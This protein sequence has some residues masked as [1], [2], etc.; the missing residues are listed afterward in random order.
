MLA[1]QRLVTSSYLMLLP[2]PNGQTA[3]CIELNP[4]HNHQVSTVLT[5]AYCGVSLCY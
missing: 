1:N 5:A 4:P 3:G 2:W